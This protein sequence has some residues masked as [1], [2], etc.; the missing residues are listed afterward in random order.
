M[1]FF[2]IILA[3]PKFMTERLYFRREY[4]SRFYGWMPFAFSVILVEI[5]YIL[6]FCAFF[7]CGFYWTAGLVNTSEACGYFYIMLVFFVFWAV[8][9]GFVIAGASE[10]PLLASVINPIIISILILFAGLMQPPQSM[11][12]FWRSWMYWLDPFHYYIEGL[13]VNELATLPVVCNEG[14]LVTFTPPAGQTCGEYTENYFAFGATGY[15]ED[16]NAT[17]TCKYCT[18]SSGKE[19]Y[20]TVYQWDES[21]KWRNFGE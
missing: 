18:Y 14:D 21:H 17:D 7:M 9:L 15:I 13:A 8:T 2:Q 11:P 4:A 6:V 1:Y 12:Y 10:N 5:P 19:Y 20:S 16:V 3:Q